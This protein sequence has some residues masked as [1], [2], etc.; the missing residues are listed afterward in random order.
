MIFL[1]MHTPVQFAQDDF[2]YRCPQVSQ[3]TASLPV[4]AEKLRP[5]GLLIVDNLLW[6]GQV[7]DADD[8]MASDS[9][10]SAEQHSHPDVAARRLENTPLPF[11]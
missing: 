3:L 2:G 11:G 5:G 9:G 8:H 4:I 7:L 1:G 10:R 6:H